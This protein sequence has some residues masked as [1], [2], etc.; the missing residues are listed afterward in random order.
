MLARQVSS[1]AAPADSCQFG[2]VNCRTGG[3]VASNLGHQPPGPDAR[4][5]HS[6]REGRA[7]SV[8]VRRVCGSQQDQAPRVE[9]E[10]GPLIQLISVP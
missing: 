5:T 7:Q 4:L 2:F 3:P 8:C 9:P 1:I 10:R 6:L